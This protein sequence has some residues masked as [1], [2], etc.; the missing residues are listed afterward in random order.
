LEY[1][2]VYLNSFF[3][4]LT[5]L[6]LVLRRAKQI[7]N[8]PVVLAPHGEFSP[9]ALTFKRYKKQPFIL[10]AKL[11]SLYQG[12]IWQAS[13]QAEE[14]D[15]LSVFSRDVARG[16]SLIRVASD[17]PSRLPDEVLK[18]VSKP[19][20]HCGSAHI[21][22][23]SRITR[24]KNLDVALNL[25]SQ[26]SGQVRFDIYG[27]I[28]DKIYWQEC[29]TLISR[30]PTRVQVEYKGMVAAES[31]IE[32][33]SQ[34]HLLLLPTRGE[35]FGHVILESLHGGCP[36]LISDQTP[37]RNL[38]EIKVGWDISLAESEKFYAALN[39]LISMDDSRFSEWSQAARE[40]ALKFV[41]DP[42][43]V[44]VN[45]KLFVEALAK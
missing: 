12:I 43:S 17:L 21:V 44:E 29:Q 37:W 33:L 36:V 19:T 9:G 3:S 14:Q 35:N 42:V 6:T 41:H 10:L 20:K 23:L 25:L 31:V 8:K 34:Y 22:F 27:P 2:L 11:A 15:I 18:P 4:R 26:V 32:I 1:D 24:T 30:L 39:D 13:T 28:E 5:I 38:A 7:P 16:D 45:R 40:H